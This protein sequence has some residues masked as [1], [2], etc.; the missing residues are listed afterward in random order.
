VRDVYET[1]PS[2]LSNAAL[3]LVLANVDGALAQTRTVP[4]LGLNN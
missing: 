2:I 3:L 1:L 4:R